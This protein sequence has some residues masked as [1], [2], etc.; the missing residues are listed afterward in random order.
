MGTYRMNLALN[1]FGL[2][3]NNQVKNIFAEPK[4]FVS[5]KELANV[6][7]EIEKTASS[8]IES[9]QK[10]IFEKL[11][12]G[13]TSPQPDRVKVFGLDSQLDGNLARQIATAK[14]GFNINISDNARSAIAALNA[15]AAQLQSKVIAQEKILETVRTLQAH[16]NQMLTDAVPKKMDGKIYLPFAGEAL[17]DTKTIFSYNGPVEFHNSNK[18]DKDGKGSNSSGYRGKQEQENNEDKHNLDLVF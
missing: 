18:L 13:Q 1:P 2:N 15:S 10:N 4:Q 12:F 6:N 16:K 14:S 8:K 7:L 11:D 9:L 17:P 3:N 5:G